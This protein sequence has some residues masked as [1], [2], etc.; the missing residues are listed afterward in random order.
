MP[1]KT[2]GMRRRRKKKGMRR[3]RRRRRKKKKKK[4]KKNGIEIVRTIKRSMSAEC[5]RK[6]LHHLPADRD[7]ASSGHEN[8][9]WLDVRRS[10][11]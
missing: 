5:S 11:P 4:R 9:R 1:R 10:P 7:P 6:P 3:N 8:A 2:E